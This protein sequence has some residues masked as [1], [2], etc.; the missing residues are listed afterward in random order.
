MSTKLRLILAGFVLACSALAAAA[1]SPALRQSI[2]SSGPGREHQRV[3]DGLNIADWL[4]NSGGNVS[5][6]YASDSSGD[7]GKLR[8]ICEASHLAYDDPI[9]APGAAGTTHLHQFFGNTLTNASST[10]QSL[11]VSGSGSCQGG[12]LN[13]SGY[14]APA[15]IQ[16]D[17]SKVVVPDY[18]EFYYSVNRLELFDDG[19]GGFSSPACTCGGAGQGHY[20][21]DSGQALLACPMKPVSRIERGMK[22]IMGHVATTGQKPSSYPASYTPFTWSCA[23]GASKSV[24][25]DDATPSNGVEG[26]AAGTHIVVRLEGAN[27]WDGTYGSGNYFTHLTAGSQDGYG[28][29]ICPATHPN[30]IPH[31]TVIIGYSHA[32]EADYSKW[33]LSSDIFNGATFRAGETF[34]TDFLWAWNDTIQD[35]WHK[36][37][38]GMYP[39]PGVP[40]YTLNGSGINAVGGDHVA[41]TNDGGLRID[42]PGVGGGDSL[43]AGNLGNGFTVSSVYVT[44]TNVRYIPIP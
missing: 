40:R 13:R 17:T 35:H 5:D 41:A 7:E 38:N 36:E 27:C 30:R 11:R 20:G 19:T 42:L 26:C 8:F 25:W 28:N 14:W 39:W 24:L 15:M 32:G 37:V 22:A 34:H 33:K 43:K 12:P 9:L 21:C 2:T 23:G 29:V 4:D 10:Y 31:L 3:Y 44:D 1:Y 6:S 16:T 18:I